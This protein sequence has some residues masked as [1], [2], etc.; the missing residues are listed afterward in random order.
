MIREKWK[1][2]QR[3]IRLR[4][5]LTKKDKRILVSLGKM[6]SLK[7]ENTVWDT[8]SAARTSIREE[9]PFHSWNGV[10]KM[11]AESGNKVALAVLQ[12]LKRH[13]DE[14]EVTPPKPKPGVTHQ[15]D[16]QG[17]VLYLL[18]D[19]GMIKDVGQALHFSATSPS[20]KALAEDLAWRKFG[21]KFG[22]MDN[23]IKKTETKPKQK[24][25]TQSKA[26]VGAFRT[27]RA[28]KRD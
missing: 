7:E 28:A 17:N 27:I 20:A 5:D 9:F 6:Q 3:E 14:K 22:F 8:A 12:S 16:N 19:G 2:K 18:S 4:T 15:V 24:G 26:T 25:A 23:T 21:P 13:A 10:L 11:K 1:R